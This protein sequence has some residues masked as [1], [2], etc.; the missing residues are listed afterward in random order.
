MELVLPTRPTPT[1]FV[2]SISLTEHSVLVIVDDEGDVFDHWSKIIDERLA[3]IVMPLGLRPELISISGPAEM[4]DNRH[5]VLE[6]GTVFL[7]DYK[8]K[9]EYTTG[10][11]LIE[12]FRLQQKAILV[13]NHVDQ[14]DVKAAVEKL[15]IRMLPKTYM[16]NAKF[17]MKI[18]VE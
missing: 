13:T 2:N 18:G 16:L 11:Q 12:E 17:P 5:S 4:R 8:F 1:W 3:G 10:I 9:D 15:N 6:R 14:A 7:I